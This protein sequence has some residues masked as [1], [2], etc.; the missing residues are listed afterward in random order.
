MAENGV[1][2][3]NIDLSSTVDELLGNKAGDTTRIA[4]QNLIQLILTSILDENSTLEFLHSNTVYS[5]V[6]GGSAPKTM[7]FFDPAT[8]WSAT[9]GS[10]PELT[11]D[12]RG[13]VQVALDKIG[14]GNDVWG[15]PGLRGRYSTASHRNGLSYGTYSHTAVHD[16]GATGTG[17]TADGAGSF[18]G[19]PFDPDNVLYAFWAYLAKNYR[20]NN[21]LTA[22]KSLCS[23]EEHI[24][25]GRASVLNGYKNRT[26]KREQ[27]RILVEGVPTLVPVDLRLIDFKLPENRTRDIVISTEGIGNVADGFVCEATGEN[28]GT[29]SVAKGRYVRAHDNQLMGSG[30]NEGSPLTAEPDRVGL[31][32]NVTKPTIEATPG[33]GTTEGL[34]EIIARIADESGSKA[35]KFVSWNEVERIGFVPYQANSGGGTSWGMKVRQMILGVIA[36]TWSFDYNGVPS[37]MPSEGSVNR[38]GSDA[39]RIGFIFTDNIWSTNAVNVT[40]DI[41][42]K[43]IVRDVTKDELAPWGKI[44]TKSYYLRDGDTRKMYG[45][46]AQEIISAYEDA[47]LNALHTGVVTMGENGKYAVNYSMCETLR[48]EYLDQKIRELEAV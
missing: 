14:L 26:G 32:S 43:K 13:F 40:S 10:D 35:L 2:T 45:Y 16:C 19:N 48:S 22:E 5:Q 47:G 8:G 34:G 39:T 27:E 21:L 23:G 12:E 29:G 15:T 42:A 44:K 31:G 28:G 18:T 1:K 24:G 36:D 9:G 17:G 6:S 20:K 37:L 3:V 33:P 4:I 38:I 11:N 25:H 46:I 30:I 41:T 7:N